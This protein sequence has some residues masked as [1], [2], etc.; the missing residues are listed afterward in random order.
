MADPALDK[1]LAR[2]GMLAAQINAQQQQLEFLRKELQIVDEFVARWHTFASLEDGQDLIHSAV[3]VDKTKTPEKQRRPAN[4]PRESVGNFVEEILREWGR[5]ASRAELFDELVHRDVI[6]HGTD[7]QMVF[8]TMLWRMQDRFERLKGRGY[9]LK[10]ER[11]PGDPEPV[12]P[13]LKDLLGETD[14]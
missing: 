11:V 1:A 7:P 9:W 10:G 6:I 8:S 12:A 5:P 2:R 13:E 4:P 3:P 14:G